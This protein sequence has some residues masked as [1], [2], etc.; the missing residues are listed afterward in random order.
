MLDTSLKI[1]SKIGC[2]LGSFM[3]RI[4]FIIAMLFNATETKLSTPSILRI[5]F[6]IGE[7]TNASTSFR[8]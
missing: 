8:A 2:G 7:T 6:S 4:T 3:S 5:A 1:L